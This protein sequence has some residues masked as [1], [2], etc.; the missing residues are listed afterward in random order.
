MVS[1]AI[2]VPA[3]EFAFLVPKDVNDEIAA[4]RQDPKSKAFF[5]SLAALG[6]RDN[7]T[8]VCIA[9]SIPSGGHQ[10]IYVHAKIALIDDVWCTIGSANVGNRSSY[11][12]TGLNASFWNGPTVA[13]LRAVLLLE[14][15][16]IDTSGMNDVEALRLYSCISRDNTDR[17]ARGEKLAGLAFAVDPA[18]YGES[19]R[20]REDPYRAAPQDRA[21]SRAP[22]EPCGA[23]RRSYSKTL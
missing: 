18:T 20:R 8:L 14:H 19:A 22:P 6:E 23:S 9:Q 4:G 3:S 15:L 5:D 12:D 17:Y 2:L 21:H 16:E 11:G 7:F 10:N 13:A 1:P